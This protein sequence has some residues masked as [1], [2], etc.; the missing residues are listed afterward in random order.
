[1]PH[2]SIV[3]VLLVL[4]YALGMVLTPAAADDSSKIIDALTAIARAEREQSESLR[5]LADSAARCGR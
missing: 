1:M 4:G 3:V 5:K 2:T